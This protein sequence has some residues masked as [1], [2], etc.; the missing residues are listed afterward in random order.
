MKK[1]LHLL[2]HLEQEQQISQS[3]CCGCSPVKQHKQEEEVPQHQSIHFWTYYGTGN[4]GTL[5]FCSSENNIFF[6]ADPFPFPCV[7]SNAGAPLW[8][9]VLAPCKKGR[10]GMLRWLI[11]KNTNNVKED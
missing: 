3:F 2:S 7:D 4:E 5:G 6:Y 9:F 11:K 1:C 8:T 10:E